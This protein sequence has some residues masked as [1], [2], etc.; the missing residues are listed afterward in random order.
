MNINKAYVYEKLDFIHKNNNIDV[1]PYI[2]MMV[3]QEEI[4]YKVIVFI[5]KYIPIERFGTYNAIYN[6]RKNSPLFRNIVN[7]NLPIS[8]KAIVL[9]SLLTQSLIGMKHSN[10]KEDII[11]AI[12]VDVLFKAIQKYIYNNDENAVDEAFDAYQIIF[13]TL[14]PKK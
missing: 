12:N 2:D 14:F 9:S 4:P 6:K 11:D 13:R 8:E 10:N 7:A 1:Q 5:N 3:G